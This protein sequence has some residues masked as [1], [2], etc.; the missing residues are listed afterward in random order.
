MLNCDLNK[1]ALCSPVT[2]PHIFRIHLWVDC[3][4]GL[5]FCIKC[6]FLYGL[7]SNVAKEDIQVLQ[8]SSLNNIASYFF[9]YCYVTV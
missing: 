9:T 5:V 2:L 8:S 4:Q 7:S 3:F 1:V 6:V